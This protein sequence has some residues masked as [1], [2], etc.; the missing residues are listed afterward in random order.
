MGG[1][2]P[3]FLIVIPIYDDGV[4]E[5]VE[6]FVIFLEIMESELDPRDVGQVNLTRSSH[7]VIIN[8][9]GTCI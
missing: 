8:P 7:L 5:D 6:G 1:F 9:S 3:P 4:P 2:F